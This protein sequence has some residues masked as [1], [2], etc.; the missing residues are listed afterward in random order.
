MPDI[1]FSSGCYEFLDQ[2]LPI[3]NV[4]TSLKEAKGVNKEC[5]EETTF[6]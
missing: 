6:V 2:N 4:I 1:H 3:E 5:R